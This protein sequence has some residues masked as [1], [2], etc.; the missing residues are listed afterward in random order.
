MNEVAIGHGS[1]TQ[2]RE[3]PYWYVIEGV[4]VGAGG[5]EGLEGFG[6]FSILRLSKI[7]RS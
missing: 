5:A 6:G 4:G 2:A 7:L 3:R 1:S